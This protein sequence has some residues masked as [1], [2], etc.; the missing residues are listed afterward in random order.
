MTDLSMSL[1]LRLTVGKGEVLFEIK[2]GILSEENSDL[3]FKE[4]QLDYEKEKKNFERAENL[5]DDQIIS[6]EDFLEIKKIECYHTKA[7][8]PGARSSD[9]VFHRCE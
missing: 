8:A 9:A 2:G 7:F 3:K 4:I 1:C 5:I 6:D